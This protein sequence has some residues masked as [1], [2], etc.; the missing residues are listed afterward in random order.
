MFPPGTHTRCPNDDALLYALGDSEGATREALGPGSIITDKYELREQIPHRT[1]PGRT[2]RAT[3]LKLK[4][5]VE[6]RILPADS[7][8]RPSDHARFQ[9]EVATWGRLRNDHIVRLFDSGFTDQRSPYMVL[10]MV[11]DSLGDRL[12]AE[13]PQPLVRVYAVAGQALKALV[14]AHEAGVLHRD[15]NP[16]TLVA[17]SGAGGRLHVRLTGFGLAKHLAGEDEDPTAITMTGQVVGNPAYMAPETVLQGMLEPR[18]DLYA[19]GVTLYELTTGIRPYMGKTLAE[20]LDYHVRG[21][22]TPVKEL[23]RDCPDDLAWLI[24]LMMHREPD[25]RFASAEEA[26][27]ALKDKVQTPRP[28]AVAIPKSEPEPETTDVPDI[29]TAD[30]PAEETGPVSRPESRG[31][32]K[33]L[34]LLMAL[35]LAGVLGGGLW[36]WLRSQ[37]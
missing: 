9:R 22:P 2:F 1:G 34:M 35:F 10:E 20:M 4:R 21:I 31:N 13:G 14:T 36:L 12:R 28:V 19:L 23:R 18:T 26:L 33:P 11:G 30:A 15:V 32:L 6:L 24:S 8:V 3:Q 29:F 25:G 37:G 5:N 16:D 7:L 17:T 27:K